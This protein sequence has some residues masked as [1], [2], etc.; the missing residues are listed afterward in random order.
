MVEMFA[1]WVV[2]VD[3]RSAV[4]E[5]RVRFSEE[6]VAVDVVRFDPRSDE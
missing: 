3:T 2:S 4:N 5:P 6:I 1:T